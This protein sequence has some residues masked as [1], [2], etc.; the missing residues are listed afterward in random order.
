MKNAL[1]S[2]EVANAF[3]GDFTGSRAYL[4]QF[5]TTRKGE[6]TLRLRW[7]SDSASA[8]DIYGSFTSLEAALARAWRDRFVRNI[9]I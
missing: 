2:C 7:Q 1:A 3:G 6:R 4:I 9:Q 8:H 5:R